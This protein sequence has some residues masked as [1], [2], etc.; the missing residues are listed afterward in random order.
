MS[1]IVWTIGATIAGRCDW[2]LYRIRIWCQDRIA[3]QYN[4]YVYRKFIFRRH[5]LPRNESRGTEYRFDAPSL[6]R[7]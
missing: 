1:Y 2:Y 5:I 7:R 6:P 3:R 4:A